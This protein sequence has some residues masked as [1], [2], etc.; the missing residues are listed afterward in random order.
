MASGATTAASIQQV[1]VKETPVQALVHPTVTTHQTAAQTAPSSGLALA[2]AA[3]QHN[4]PPTTIQP[5]SVS[6]PLL[7]PVPGHVKTHPAPVSS[8]QPQ[9]VPSSR[10][11][12]EAAATP[13]MAP[14]SNAAYLVHP[15]PPPV[16]AASVASVSNDHVM[17]VVGSKTVEDQASVSSALRPGAPASSVQVAKQPTSGPAQTQVKPAPPNSV[18]A[19]AADMQS[20]LQPDAASPS[21]ITKPVT[22]P[23]DGRLT[24]EPLQ[25]PAKTLAP[26]TP[27]AAPAAVANLSNENSTKH[28]A[29]VP[30]ASHVTSAP[31]TGTLETLP[32]STQ[33]T[34]TPPGPPTVSGTVH[35]DSAATVHVTEPP[36]SGPLQAQAKPTNRST[37]VPETSTPA[38][39][40][41][42][43]P[44]TT[45]SN[46]LHPG[47]PASADVT[48]P[49]VSGPV[50]A[51][52]R[53]AR[54]NTTVPVTSSPARGPKTNGS[55]VPPPKAPTASVHK[56]ML[57]PPGPIQTQPKPAQASTTEAVTSTPV[58][59][60]KPVEPQANV[61][62]TLHPAAPALSVDV[63]NPPVARPTQAQ[64]IT[65]EP[66]TNIPATEVAAVA[67]RSNINRTQYPGAATPAPEVAKQ[68]SPRA[69]TMPNLSKVTQSSSGRVGSAIPKS[70]STSQIVQTKLEPGRPM[71]TNAADHAPVEARKV[72]QS[73]DIVKVGG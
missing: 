69:A 72:E 14:Q 26:I 62:S 39:G 21:H 15:G 41:P 40:T 70:S 58:T 32:A 7:V 31:A 37:T 6:V 8:A 23:A 64:H 47:A 3:I 44:Q 71:P 51:Q 4:D 45:V 19:T 5:P 61:K 11:K 33:L 24:T 17:K 30:P 10:V 50:Q 63:T 46:G 2:K 9:H 53:F 57:P 29:A 34:T 43:N 56:A 49:T 13:E 18:P 65:T 54:H 25:A 28:P 38:S 59:G 22:E 60:M 67:P 16:A 52:P 12:V 66:P 1:G 35:G 73:A 27:V 68:L 36:S 20:T 48:K 55:S 42:F